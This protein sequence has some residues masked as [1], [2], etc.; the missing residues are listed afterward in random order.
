S[1]VPPISQLPAHFLSGEI[2][3]NEKIKEEPTFCCC[4]LSKSVVI[5][6]LIHI[7]TSLTAL[8][9]SLLEMKTDE[10]RIQDHLPF[11]AAFF[12]VIS[13]FCI[14]RA[15]KVYNYR[16]YY[17]SAL[18][19]VI[20]QISVAA[21]STFA[22]AYTGFTSCD[23]EQSRKDKF[24]MMCESAYAL[25]LTIMGLVYYRTGLFLE[26]ERKTKSRVYFYSSRSKVAPSCELP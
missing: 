1:R 15:T 13:A 2:A 25:V 19:L 23:K 21:S 9:L 3:M 12:G 4:P 24:S 17:R 20:F 10:I 26:N 7:F 16:S 18:W 8:F 6:A 5:F 22:Y 11:S 14:L